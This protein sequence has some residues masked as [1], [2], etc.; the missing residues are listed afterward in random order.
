[1]MRLIC[2]VIGHK[3][4]WVSGMKI[5]PHVYGPG[6]RYCDRCGVVFDGD[7]PQVGDRQRIEYR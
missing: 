1:M 5:G 6:W 2:R 4:Y 7:H 3:P